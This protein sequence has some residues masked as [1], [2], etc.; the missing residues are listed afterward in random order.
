MASFRSGLLLAPGGEFAFVAFGESV[1]KGILPG[2]LA[3]ELYLVRRFLSVLWQFLEAVS[4][5][6][7]VAMETGVVSDGG[8]SGQRSKELG[9]GSWV[10]WVG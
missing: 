4:V 3:N 9:G 10:C 8:V 7:T 5:S 6:E 1:A 2:A